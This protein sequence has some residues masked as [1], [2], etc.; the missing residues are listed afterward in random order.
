MKKSLILFCLLLSG[1]SFAQAK[2]ETKPEI[3]R[4]SA[5][6]KL[7]LR[8]AQVET[9]QSYQSLL[10]TAEYKKFES[11]Q[12]HQQAVWS[13]IMNRYHI[14]PRIQL[15]D[16][17]SPTAQPACQ[18]VPEGDMEFRSNTKEPSKK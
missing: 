18:G 5:E 16:S 11:A 2:P 6:D 13:D 15:C 7:A 8:T 17:L 3:P 1:T 9:M 4:M 14:D 12:L 10:N